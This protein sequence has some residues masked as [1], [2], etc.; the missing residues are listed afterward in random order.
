M[1]LEPHHVAA[2]RERFGSAYVTHALCD[3]HSNK[4]KSPVIALLGLSV[5]A[6][7]SS[8]A[9]SRNAIQTH[10]LERSTIIGNVLTDD[11]KVQ[12]HVGRE[13]ALRG[14]PF[15]LEIFSGITEKLANFISS[16][17][18]AIVGKARQWLAAFLA[19]AEKFFDFLAGVYDGN[20]E[21][22]SILSSLRDQI[23][24]NWSAVAALGLGGFYK[25]VDAVKDL[26]GSLKTAIHE[27]VHGFGSF[28]GQAVQLIAQGGGIVKQAAKQAN[29]VVFYIYGLYNEF[30]TIDRTEIDLHLIRGTALLPE[31]L[32][33]LF[34]LI[35]EAGALLTAPL[36]WLAQTAFVQSL[37]GATASLIGGVMRVFSYA[38][39]FVQNMLAKAA[40]AVVGIMHSLFS[41][42]IAYAG[43]VVNTLMVRVFGEGSQDE[44][45]RLEETLLAGRVCA[46][47]AES[48]G[49][50]EKTREALRSSAR[51]TQTMLELQ[52]AHQQQAS[53]SERASV[54]AEM[55]AEMIMEDDPLDN[56]ELMD[57][58][59]LTLTGLD[60]D[61]Y[62]QLGYNLSAQQQGAMLQ[63]VQD[64]QNALP[65]PKTSGG[66]GD[67]VRR[68]R[69][70]FEPVDGPLDTARADLAERTRQFN[71]GVKVLDRELNLN[72]AD[73]KVTEL[74]ALNRIREQII[75]ELRT[76]L[77][78]T[79]LA[80][81]V[82]RLEEAELTGFERPE[83]I[84][85]GTVIG[86]AA[87]LVLGSLGLAAWLTYC[88]R[89]SELTL[90][91]E[92]DTARYFT[93]LKR[94][95]ANSPMLA[96]SI[97]VFE[98][99]E[100][101]S[102]GVLEIARG[103]LDKPRIIDKWR[104]HS[105]LWMHHVDQGQW[106]PDEAKLFGS[107]AQDQL[108]HVLG[109]H[110]EDIKAKLEKGY[111][112]SVVDYMRTNALGTDPSEMAAVAITMASRPSAEQVEMQNYLRA[113]KLTAFGETFDM[114][115]KW[116]APDFDYSRFTIGPSQ[117]A[118]E[119]QWQN[120]VRTVWRVFAPAIRSA[121]VSAEIQ[122]TA[123]RVSDK[124]GPWALVKGVATESM[125][126]I[127]NIAGSVGGVAEKAGLFGV[128]WE[129]FT[130]PRHWF[131]TAAEGGY[132]QALQLVAV[133]GGALAGVW[134][135]TQLF[136]HIIYGVIF[137]LFAKNPQQLQW[138]RNWAAVAAKILGVMGAEFLAATL[139]VLQI[140]AASLLSL[141]AVVVLA[142]YLV[143]AVVGKALSSA[144]SAA[145]KL[146]SGLWAL[147]GGTLVALFQHLRGGK[148][149][150][151]NPILHLRVHVFAQVFPD[152][153][154]YQGVSEFPGIYRKASKPHGER[155]EEI[156]T[157]HRRRPAS[158]EE[159]ATTT[160]EDTEATTEEQTPPPRPQKKASPVLQ[161]KPPAP[162]QQETVA[163]RNKRWASAF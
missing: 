4:G 127:R 151:L 29:Y 136:V 2:L 94:R 105:M 123:L 20:A 125:N 58:Y 47:M 156:L 102:I 22:L 135:A 154:S 163:D 65:V 90:L 63:A 26:L 121:Q 113:N 148:E 116:V 70:A 128:S 120:A 3:L 101:T 112:R 15:D 74:A 12:A 69:G 33:T 78:L 41:D 111:W 132:P 146:A 53:L 134:G 126:R 45:K 40:S 7:R 48:D 81:T 162:Q 35:R 60:R 67:G 64:K 56:R 14:L 91:K 153:A 160:S 155:V 117:Y 75:S 49:L 144:W 25:V 114:V 30:L 88:A 104:E 16:G 143:Q 32:R 37:I 76:R 61:T 27:A 13:I 131:Q 38:L 28:I 34:S 137:F 21:S 23:A 152:D 100:R 93:M 157:L 92:K 59:C 150:P 119:V 130:D 158:R 96:Q 6:P 11:P 39:S 9:I 107:I 118:N 43:Q 87:V 52:N 5:D 106:T 36:T 139:G 84:A 140:R 89:K 109:S 138:Y 85:K 10:L 66:A 72:A 133:A 73:W 79:E 97:R 115:T 124:E 86:V 161:R 44:D 50:S 19:G 145:S 18:S 46:S 110:V 103:E 57:R 1:R 8:W 51:N 71:L 17:I 77:E 147:T 99:K 55:V 83:A 108:A 82:R 68:R 149:T 98:E 141:G 62:M 24:L 95:T 31:K 122:E 42:C 159:E 80:D 129:G 54:K 142:L